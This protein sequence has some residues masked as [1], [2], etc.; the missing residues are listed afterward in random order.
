MCR[1]PRHAIDGTFAHGGAFNPYMDT[2]WQD[3]RHGFRSLFKSPAFTAAVV[4]TLG[5]GVG[6]NAAVF[7]IVNRI[8]LKPLPVQDPTGL[9][10][11]A[12]EHEGNEQPHNVSWLDYQ[13]YLRNAPFQDLAAYTIGFVGLSADQRADRLAVSYVT[14]NFFSMLGVPP[15]YG[16]VLQ[17]AEAGQPG[18]DPVVILGHAYWKRR[19]NSDP[20]VVGRRVLVNGQPFIVAGVVPQSFQGVYAL[21]EFDAYLP[22]TMMPAVEYQNTVTKRDEHA[23]HVIGRLK[24]GVGRGQAQAAIDVVA[25]QL[26][27]QYPETNKTVRA[28]LIPERYARPEANSADST[29]VVAGIFLVLVALVLL[30]ACV[31]VINLVMVR[32]TVRQREL[33][34]RAALGAGRGRLIRQLLTESL[35]LAVLGGIAGAVL[36]RWCIALLSRIRL[37]GDL[38]FR[39]DFTFDWRVFAYI[40]AVAL[41]AGIG[42]GVLPALRASRTELNAVLR[43]GGRGSSDGGRRQRMR[44]VLVV[45]Q[46]AISLVLLVAAGLFVRSAMSAASVDLGFD[47]SSVLNASVDVAQQ[48]YDERRGRVFYDELLRRARQL[49][50]VQAASLAYSVPLGYY[51]TAAFLEIEGQPPQTKARK[52]V[53]GFNVVTPEYIDTLKPR[54][55]KGR[56]IQPQDD[57]RSRPVVVVNEYMANRFWPKQDPIGRR[58]RSTD[59]DN[60][61][62]EVVGVVHNA[63]ET[64]LFDDPESYFFV[65]L[66]QNYRSLRVLQLRTA[67]D[68]ATLIPLV[69]REIRALDADLPVFDVTT[70]KQ[71]IEG[72]N[73]FFLL[74]MGALF[75]GAM[76]LLGLLLALV[77]VY[78]VVSYAASQRTQEIGVRMALGAGRLDILQLVLGRGLILIGVGVG[79]GVLAAL[80]VSRLVSNLLF[81]ISAI[82]PV[83]F[84][85]VPMI[86]ATMALAA[87]YFPAFR[88]TRIDPAIALRTE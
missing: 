66:A 28:R 31:N 50:G 86:L 41:M 87:S 49:P 60:R 68:P 88:A 10:V 23:L 82:D 51:N 54:L 12:V 55:V 24:P 36:G 56:F 22:L 13:D 16:R 39:F 72:P 47:P 75:G 46:V 63:K 62:L 67:G 77:G 40:A 44:S 6:A 42:V 61:W 26:E 84:I 53:G 45:A 29:P 37:P 52:P 57:E 59:L 19:F 74:R 30:V 43:E 73:G 9:Y 3:V 25:Q 34:V 78:G 35:L 58:F 32:A 8:L 81:G 80:S 11:L 83:T 71:T 38:P 5:L 76:G 79:V 69:Q 17:P 1:R 14:S 70:M 20:G 48:G 27:R 15:A 21:V 85:G 4:L 33:A 7:T 65:P 18:T 2:L 64:G